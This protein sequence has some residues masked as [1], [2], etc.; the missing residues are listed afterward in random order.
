MGPLYQLTYTNFSNIYHKY[1]VNNSNGS[2]PLSAMAD[3]Q[4]FE[5]GMIYMLQDK[6]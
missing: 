2:M 6:A 3:W 1:I 4:W 5:L